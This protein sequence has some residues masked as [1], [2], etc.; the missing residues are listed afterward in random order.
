MKKIIRGKEVHRRVISQGHSLMVTIPPAVIEELSIRRGDPI[1]IGTDGGRMI[2]EKVRRSR[3]PV[4]P[5]DD[6][7]QH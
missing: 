2:V 6:I 3:D 5:G 1:E 4:Q 7:C